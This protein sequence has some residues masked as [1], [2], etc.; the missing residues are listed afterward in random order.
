MSD[1]SPHALHVIALIKNC[2]DIAIVHQELSTARQ[3]LRN[4]RKYCK[5][6][7]FDVPREIFDMLDMDIMDKPPAFLSKQFMHVIEEVEDLDRKFK[8]NH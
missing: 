2:G 5:E 4:I 1:L 6:I 3:E 8:S 7:G